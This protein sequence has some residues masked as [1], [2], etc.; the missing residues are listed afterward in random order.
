MIEWYKI[1]MFQNYANFSGRAR[2]SEYWYFRLVTSLLL[3]GFI[4]LAV[5][6]SVIAGGMIGFPIAFGLIFL[7][8]IASLIPSLAVTVRRMHDIGKSGWTI[9]VALIPLAGPIWVLVLLITEGEYG[10]NYY[11]PDP[12]NINGE[13]NDIGINN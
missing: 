13:I 10:D 6:I 11:G 7:Y 1:A 5:M 12:K 8:L 9:L 2:R 4:I 3:F